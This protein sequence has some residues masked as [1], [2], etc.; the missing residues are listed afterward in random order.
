MTDGADAFNQA[1]GGEKLPSVKLQVGDTFTGVLEKVTESPRGATDIN[2]EVKTY[3]SGDPIP[4]FIF[5]LADASDGARKALFVEKD[6]R[7]GRMFRVIFDASQGKISPGGTLDLRRIPDLAPT[8]QGLSGMAQFEAR[9]TPG[10]PA[11][12]TN[13]PAPQPAPQPAAAPAPQPAPAATAGS[14]W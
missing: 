7:D 6:N 13:E 8:A 9:W 4:L 1:G 14:S 12:F 3:P 2:G 5:T 11:S 10:A